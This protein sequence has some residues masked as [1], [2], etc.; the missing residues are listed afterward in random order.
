MFNDNLKK[1]RKAASLSQSELAE[2]LFVTRQCVSKWEQGVNQPDLG[3]LQKLSQILSVSVDELV[4]GNESAD[5][6]K[7]VSINNKLFCICALASVF[8]VAV[9]FI[10][11]RFLPETI[12]AH[13]TGGK[14]DRYGS[15]YEILYHLAAVAVFLTVDILVFFA[16]RKISDNRA[17]AIAH[18]VMIFILVAYLVFICVIYCNYLTE[19]ISCATCISAVLLTILSVAMHPKWNKQNALFGVRCR[20]TLDNPLIWKKVNA[21]ACYLFTAVSVGIFVFNI[22]LPFSLSFL[23]LLSYLLAVS[24]VLI[25][26]KILSHKLSDES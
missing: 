5:R 12:P 16:L 7:T 4:C 25:Y 13:F 2:K 21:F 3:T 9:V 1:Y 22:L 26:C 18:G 20:A 24:A 11:L 23:T 6:A 17:A 14:V 8:L 10:F 15:K 19:V